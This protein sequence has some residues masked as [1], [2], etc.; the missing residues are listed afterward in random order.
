[1]EGL[2]R[3]HPVIQHEVPAPPVTLAPPVAANTSDSEP[4]LITLPLFLSYSAE[5]TATRDVWI[6][7]AQA[8]VADVATYQQ[9]HKAGYL[10]TEALHRLPPTHEPRKVR[11]YRRNVAWTSMQ[12]STL[13]PTG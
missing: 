4:A 8:H 6:C 11:E 7:A 10:T 9:Q 5:R 2:S 3:R 12:P 1:M 13:P